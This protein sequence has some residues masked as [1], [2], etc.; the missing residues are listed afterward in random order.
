[1]VPTVFSPV[2]PFAVASVPVNVMLG[3]KPPEEA[4]FPEAVTAVTPPEAGVAQAGTPKTVVRTCPLVPDDSDMFGVTPPEDARGVLA[5]TAETPT[6]LPPLIVPVTRRLPFMIVLA[7]TVEVPIVTSPFRNDGPS[8]VS[9]NT[10]NKVSPLEV[11][12]SSLDING[13]CI[14]YL[15]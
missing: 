12:E 9:W 7:L 13:R 15:G 14:L 10:S 11:L 3:V 4:M 8:A 1:M 5:V 2:P 6:R